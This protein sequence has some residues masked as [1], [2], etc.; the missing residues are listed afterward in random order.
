MSLQIARKSPQIVRK[1]P[2]NFRFKH[3]KEFKNIL[4]QNTVSI[5]RKII[6]F[7]DNQSPTRM[8][9]I[10]SEYISFWENIDVDFIFKLFAVFFF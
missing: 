7:G 1:S 10:R 9:L 5:I 4:F 8:A 3:I 6:I 2:H